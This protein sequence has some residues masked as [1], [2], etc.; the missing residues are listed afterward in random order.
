MKLYGWPQVFAVIYAPLISIGI[1]GNI[2]SFY[3]FR[4][5][6]KSAISLLLSALSL[7]DLLLLFFA[8][9]LSCLCMLPIGNMRTSHSIQS[10][11]LI[12][13]TKYLYPPLVAAKTA[14][15]YILGAITI[16]RWFAVFKPLQQEKDQNTTKMLLH[17]T[18][19]FGLC[20]FFGVAVKVA[21]CIFDRQTTENALL[22]YMH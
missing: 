16:E 21:E 2:L 19:F 3:I 7:C 8:L 17:V 22:L 11:M 6:K 10:L 15:L 5:M 18:V 1:F 13:S 20:H 12:Y 9:P 4:K 14:S